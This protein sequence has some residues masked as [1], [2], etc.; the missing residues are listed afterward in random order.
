M[1]L[2]ESQWRGKKQSVRFPYSIFCFITCVFAWLCLA[3]ILNL[4]SFSFPKHTVELRVSH[5]PFLPQASLEITLTCIT[6][7]NEITARSVRTKVYCDD[8]LVT[9]VKWPIRTLC[10][11]E[12]P[13]PS[14]VAETSFINMP[15]H[16]LTDGIHH[17]TV[18]S[19]L[20]RQKWLPFSKPYENF[21]SIYS[22]TVKGGRVVCL[23]PS[24]V[25]L[26]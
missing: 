16:C 25:S 19:A 8:H 18:R 20:Y 22:A 15:A 4:L 5:E 9:N 26:S 12:N 23:V 10:G 11:P 21:Q 13:P 7:H 14:N 3:D 24:S 17:I 2:R 1:F 6:P